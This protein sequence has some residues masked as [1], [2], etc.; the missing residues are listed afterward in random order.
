MCRLEVGGQCQGL[1]CLQVRSR[2][3]VSRLWLCAGEKQV[4]C[5][6]ELAVYMASVLCLGLGCVQVRGTWAVSRPWL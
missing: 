4:G 5:V 6:K 3:A 1:G 2:W